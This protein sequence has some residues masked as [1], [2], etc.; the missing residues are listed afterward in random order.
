MEIIQI[1]IFSTAGLF[2]DSRLLNL[3]PGRNSELPETPEP[4][5]GVGNARTAVAFR[6]PLASSRGLQRQGSRRKVLGLESRLAADFEGHKKF[7]A[8]KITRA[9]ARSRKWLRLAFQTI[10]YFANPD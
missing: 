7:L 8:N 1:E 2:P 4:I 10:V 5:G 9:R 3:A 6:I